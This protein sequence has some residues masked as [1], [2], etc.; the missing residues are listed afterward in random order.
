MEPSDSASTLA[1]DVP[2]F[3]GPRYYRS[4]L[5][6]YMADISEAGCMVL[7]SGPSLSYYRSDYNPLH[8]IYFILHSRF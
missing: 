8:R 6:P 7:F 4:L 3:P 2:I 5:F 1:R